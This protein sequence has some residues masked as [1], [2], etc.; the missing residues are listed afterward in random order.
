MLIQ[1][2]H[3]VY[4]IALRLRHLAAILIL[5]MAKHYDIAIWGLMEQYSRDSDE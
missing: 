3:R 2:I 4:G 1:C 5:Y